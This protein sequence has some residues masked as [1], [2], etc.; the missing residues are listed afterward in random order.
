[1]L[2]RQEGVEETDQEV[3]IRFFT[4]EFFEAEVGQGVEVD[5]LH[6]DEPVSWCGSDLQYSGNRKVNL[7]L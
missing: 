3:F 1:M 7:L 2:L 6:A 4:E 5:G